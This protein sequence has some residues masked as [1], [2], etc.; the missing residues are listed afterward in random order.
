M[1]KKSKKKSDNVK[2]CD[3]CGKEIKGKSYKVYDENF[4]E[5]R[6]IL[7]CE[8]CFTITLNL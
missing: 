3:F 6:G 2:H 1:K 7:Q 5:Q 8:K 4:N